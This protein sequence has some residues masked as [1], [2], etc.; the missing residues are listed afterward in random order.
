MPAYHLGREGDPATALCS[1]RIVLI[2]DSPVDVCSLREAE[3]CR[4]CLP[5]LR[6]RLLALSAKL[7]RDIAAARA[8]VR[9]AERLLEAFRRAGWLQAQPE[10]P[11]LGKQRASR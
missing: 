5:E 9:E 1:T 4:K 11:K 10:A 3:V 8:A 2:D 7:D 6:R